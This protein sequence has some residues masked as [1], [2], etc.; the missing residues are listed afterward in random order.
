MSNKCIF[1]T[2]PFVFWAFRDSQSL[3]TDKAI[4][5]M[6]GYDKYVRKV[7]SD[8]SKEEVTKY[9]EYELEIPA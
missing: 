6:D 8:D 1:E 7:V 3:P 9:K 4:W 2:G 5:V